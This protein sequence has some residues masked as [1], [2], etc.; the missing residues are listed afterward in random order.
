MGNSQN[1]TGANSISQAAQERAMYLGQ[2]QPLLQSKIQKPT[3]DGNISV[4]FTTAGNKHL[5]NDTLGRAS[6]FA[7]S[8]LATLDTAL[9]NASFV[10][11]APLSKPRTDGITKFYY[12]KDST[13][14]LYYN[15]AEKEFVRKNGK[16]KYY[17]FLYS[18]TNT[19]R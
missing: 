5:Y 15:V 2:M 19:I 7:K 6:G 10:K 3:D 4:G 9:A 16:K 14:N 1:F 11:P 18:V 12:Y 8:D 13:R 17:R